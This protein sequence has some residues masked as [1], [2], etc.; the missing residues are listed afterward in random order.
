MSSRPRGQGL[1]AA[2]GAQS[3]TR[4]GAAARSRGFPDTL[5]TE[6]QGTWERPAEE[7]NSHFRSGRLEPRETGR[8]GTGEGL[9]PAPRA[10]GA[11][12]PPAGGGGHLSGAGGG[13]TRASARGRGPARPQGLPDA[14]ACAGLC[15]RNLKGAH[16]RSSA[17]PA[18]TGCVLC[19][20]EYDN[21]NSRF[22]NLLTSPSNSRI[23]T[24]VT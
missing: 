6:T 2:H 4:L 21:S 22:I 10:G 13:S 16:S 23:S 15:R 1:A 8:A 3:R 19:H 5:R 20:T 11:V 9:A 18:L 7:K 14:K 12:R 24:G 17:G